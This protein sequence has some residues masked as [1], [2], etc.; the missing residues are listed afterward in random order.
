[1]KFSQDELKGREPVPA[2]IYEV[3]FAGFSP[4]KSSKGDSVNLNGMGL[5]VGR[6]DL[7]PKR[8]IY[9][10]LNEQIPGFIQDFVHSFGLPMEDQNGENPSIPGNFDGDPAKFKEE[11]PTTWVYKGPLIA[12]RAKWEVSVKDYNGSQQQDI[13]KFIC[14]VDK[15]AEKFPK[16]R[17]AKEMRKTK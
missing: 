1:M 7:G 6:P 8:I 17:H 4:K 12:Q 5:I 10:G 9:A 11:D 15:C 14:K 2:D 3:E 16:V 13:V